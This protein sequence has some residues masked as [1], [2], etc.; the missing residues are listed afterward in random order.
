MRRPR[1]WLELERRGFGVTAW[2]DHRLVPPC[3]VVCVQRG[4]T[5]WYGYGPSL[6]EALSNVI[7]TIEEYAL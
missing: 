7:E 6:R 4:V 2:F 3:V 5:T 1:G